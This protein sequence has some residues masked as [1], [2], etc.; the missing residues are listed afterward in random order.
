MLACRERG[1]ERLCACH[2]EPAVTA[3]ETGVGSAG[4]R[5][6]GVPKR[7]RGRNMERGGKERGGSGE[8]S[9]EPR[10]PGSQLPGQESAS[11]RRRIADGELGRESLE[12]EGAPGT[13]SRGLVPKG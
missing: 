1:R 2:S 9:L 10:R 4:T 8:A 13:P 6:S 3:R 11:I 12:T 5:E 7:E